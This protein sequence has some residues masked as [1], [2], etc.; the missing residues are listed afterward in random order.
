MP[1]PGSIAPSLLVAMPQLLDP[2]FHRT[3]VL[4]VKHTDECAIGFVVN[5]PTETRAADAVVLDPPANGDSGLCLWTGGPVD[6][7]RGF[8]LLGR[9][10][11]TDPESERVVEGFHLTASLD[12]LRQLIETSPAA[13]AQE[14]CRLLLGYAG[15]GPGQL[16]HELAESAWLLAPID[17]AVVFE[18]APDAMW[19][20]AIRSLGIE[21]LALQAAP[22]IQ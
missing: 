5:R 17:P 9:D 22:G 16:D 13:L 19:E 7:H 14:R 3:V 15:W 11:E 2:N 12:V 1:D 8:L 6:P 20:R 18:T 10:P 4:L 21:P